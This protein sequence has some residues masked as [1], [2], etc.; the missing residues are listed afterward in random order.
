MVLLMFLTVAFLLVWVLLVSL[1][2]RMSQSH[3][4]MIVAMT[5]GMLFGLLIGTWSGGLVWPGNLFLS[6]AISMIIGMIVGFFYGLPFGGLTALEGTMSGIMG[7]MMGAMTGGM[8][9]PAYA[10][11]ML[12]ILFVLF[13]GSTLMLVYLLS[14]NHKEQYGVLYPVMWVLFFLLFEFV[15]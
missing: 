11:L 4:G 1:D 3:T 14:S 15:S 12:K 6:T 7:G 10:S 13:T 2:H 9:P 5:V 8:L